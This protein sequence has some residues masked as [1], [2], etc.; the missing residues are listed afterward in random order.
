MNSKC[1]VSFIK[2]IVESTWFM[3]HS[4]TASAMPNFFLRFPR[5]LNSEKKQDESIAPTQQVN[6]QIPNGGG[7]IASNQNMN[8]VALSIAIY[9][10]RSV[11][12]R[13]IN[14]RSKMQVVREKNENGHML[15]TG[16]GW[17]PQTPLECK[18]WSAIRT[19]KCHPCMHTF[20]NQSKC[21]QSRCEN[22][23]FRD[24]WK[25]WLSSV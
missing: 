7:K 11:K 5:W 6:K 14:A 25:R 22:S 23:K 17:T 4:L 2:S 9:H 21:S 12:V 18:F 10:F 24:Q 13:K 3:S 8:R 16:G 20:P 1:R 19:T 15:K